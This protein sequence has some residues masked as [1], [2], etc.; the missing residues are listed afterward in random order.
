MRGKTEADEIHRK[1]TLTDRIETRQQSIQHPFAAEQLVLE[2]QL[3]RN[4]RR[5]LGQFV[6]GHFENEHVLIQLIGVVFIEL[7]LVFVVHLLLIGDLLAF[8]FLNVLLVDHL[9]AFRNQSV[10]RLRTRTAVHDSFR[11]T[12]RRR[13]ILESRIQSSVGR[14]EFTAGCSNGREEKPFRMRSARTNSLDK[15]QIQAE[16]F[17]LPFSVTSEVA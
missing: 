17:N 9:L 12:G 1:R 6:E 13:Y 10:D 7:R 11:W 15:Q 16:P 2:D 14:V 3:V 5:Y 8:A 4:E